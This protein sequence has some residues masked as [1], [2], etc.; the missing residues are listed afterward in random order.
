VYSKV[1][2]SFFN[3]YIRRDLAQARELLTAALPKLAALSPL[4]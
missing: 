3:S 4:S 2:N 1:G